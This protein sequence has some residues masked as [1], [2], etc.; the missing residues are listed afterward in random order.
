MT[1]T[2]QQP[3]VYLV[4]PS[5]V[6]VE[7]CSDYELYIKLTDMDEVARLST[8]KTLNKTF[9]YE[10]FNYKTLHSLYK[11]KVVNENELE[12]EYKSKAQEEFE[13]NYIKSYMKL[14]SC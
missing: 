4:S 5:G 6:K 14:M 12:D 7:M 13:R 11:D 10:A 2:M 8:I 1:S 3:K 9:G